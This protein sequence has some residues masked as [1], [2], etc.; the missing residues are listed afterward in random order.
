MTT[1]TQARDTMVA[2]LNPAWLAQYPAVPIYYEDTTQISLDTVGNMFLLVTITFPDSV[3]QGVD[4]SPMTRT[5]GELNLRLFSKEGSGVRTA[6]GVFDFLTA[7]LK[8]KPLSGITLDVPKCGARQSRDG[9]TSRDLD[10][11]FS[12][13]Q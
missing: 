10:V 9:W 5:W 7:T 3:R 13:F 1:L 2:Y 4:A 11:S 8:Y 6:L 12:F